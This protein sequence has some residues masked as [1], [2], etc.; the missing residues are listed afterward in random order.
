[1]YVQKLSILVKAFFWTVHASYVL[2]RTKRVFTAFALTWSIFIESLKV[3]VF[4]GVEKKM[5]QVVY[6]GLSRLWLVCP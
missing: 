4:S 2:P 1:M 5:P 6:N 3:L